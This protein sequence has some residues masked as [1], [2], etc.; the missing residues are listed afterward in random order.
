[1][2]Y[3]FV[4]YQADHVSAE[5][6]R[7]RAEAHFEQMDRRRSVREFSDEPVSRSVIEDLVRT[8]STAPSGA[9]RQP[10]SFVAVSDPVIKRKIREA[11][12][13]EERISYSGRMPK[14][15]LQ[16]LLP[17]GTT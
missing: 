12:E 16:A 8:A 9:H 2:K 6:V 1:M 10:W 3:P 14:E 7:M 4:P 11:A 17:I 5:E 13:E 15:W